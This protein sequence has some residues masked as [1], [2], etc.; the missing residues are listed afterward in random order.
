MS[1]KIGTKYSFVLK[2]AI[3]PRYFLFTDKPVSPWASTACDGL[4]DPGK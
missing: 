1:Y 3:E 4:V 2:K